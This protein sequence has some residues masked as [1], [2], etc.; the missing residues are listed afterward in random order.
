MKLGEKTNNYGQKANECILFCHNG[1]KG[2][3]QLYSDWQDTIH[4]CLIY[5]NEFCKDFNDGDGY[6]TSH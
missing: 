1:R 3:C 4:P 6:G 2:N 5:Q